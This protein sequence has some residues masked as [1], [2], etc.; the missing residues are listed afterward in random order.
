MRIDVRKRGIDVGGTIPEE[1]RDRLDGD[2]AL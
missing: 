2:S 1:I